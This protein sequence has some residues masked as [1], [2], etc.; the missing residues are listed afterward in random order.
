MKS[1]T[2]YVPLAGEVDLFAV[3]RSEFELEGI[4]ER[5]AFAVESME[6]FVET[7]WPKPDVIVLLELESNLGRRAPGWNN[8]SLRC[9]EEYVP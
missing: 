1:E 4:L 5:M 7:P 8:G 9:G 3:G 2:I 6:G